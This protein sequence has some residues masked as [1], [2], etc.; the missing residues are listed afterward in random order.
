MISSSQISQRIPFSRADSRLC[1]YYLFVWSNFNFLHNSKSITFSTQSC[2]LLYSFALFYCIRLWRNWSFRFYRHV[3]YICYF[4]KVFL[5]NF[6][7]DRVLV[8]LLCAAIRRDSPSPIRFSFP[9]PC[10]FVWDFAYLSLEMSIQ[11]FFFSFLFSARFCYIHTC[12]VD[13]VARGCNQ[14]SFALF[15]ILSS[16]R[17]KDVLTLSVI[18][19]SPL[20]PSIFET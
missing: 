3:I 14:F 10:F 15:L 17:L 13:I 4:V 18:L 20:P 7:F 19:V 12:V 6:C 8:T 5:V 11:L 16:S 1:V 2:L 9:C